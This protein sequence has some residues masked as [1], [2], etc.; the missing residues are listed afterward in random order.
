MEKFGIGQA[1]RRK[2]DVRL[3][4]GQG[5]YT[6][7]INLEGQAYSAILRSPLAH[8]DFKIIDVEAAKAMPGVIAVLTYEDTE[9]DGL[10]TIPCQVN[11]KCAT[12]KEMFTPPRYILAKDR[13]RFAGEPIAFVIAESRLQALDATEAIDVE[14]EELP[15]LASTHTAGEPDLDPIWPERPENF[16]AHWVSH[17]SG[18]VDKAF[19]KA[20]KT[21]TVE[22]VNNRVIGSPMEPR[23]AIGEY[24]A[25]TDTKILRSPT[26][27]VNKIRDAL[28]STFYKIDPERIRVIS[29]DTGGGFGVRSKMYLESILCLWAAEK[30]KRPVKWQAD[31]SETFLSDTHAR[32]QVSILE[33]AF[34]ED[35]KVLGMRAE[36][37]ANVGA[38]LSDN[39]PR[40][41]TVAGGRIA[42]TVYDVPAMRHSVRACFSNTHPTDSYRGA[43]RPELCYQME[44]LMDAGAEAFGIGRDEIRRR[45]YIKPEQL[46]YTNQMGMEIDSGRFQETMEMAIEVSD[47][48]NFE[49]RRTEA[50]KRGKLRG[51]GM[52]YYVEASG[53][54]PTEWARVALD[55]DGKAQ[56][57]VGTYN[58]GQ[59]HETAFG[60]ILSEK[61]G[62][63]FHNIDFHQGDTAVI[64]KGNGTGGS[65][66][67]Q[68][69]G[70]AI[71]RAADLVIEKAKKIAA[72]KMEAAA[73]DIEFN[74]GI[75]TVAGTDLSLPI[76]EVARAAYDPDEIPDD[77]EL[78]L[79]EDILYERDTECNFPN[80]CHIAEV[81]LDKET[82]EIEVV[83]YSAVDDCGIIINPLIVR[84]QV[85]GGVAMGLGQ[86]LTERT[87]YDPDTGQLITGSYMDYGMPRADDFPEMK[88]A[89]NM[90]RN[91]SNDLGVK[92]IGEGGACGAPPAIIGAISDALGITHIDMPVS[93]QDV[94]QILQSQKA[95]AE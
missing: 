65:R 1:V 73:A 35:A 41:P 21:V 48:D 93:S 61:L 81:E 40:I 27:G 14:Y 52:G 4:T 72:H 79:D 36:T 70:V 33:M 37:I 47:W 31:R 74:D 53:G 19:A 57:F 2:E 87:E 43:G 34:D 78:G 77:E 18:P 5:Q 69:G 44:R 12:G 59:G 28:A 32:D 83:A 51:I 91:P 29:T 56:L 3:V 49:P 30:L 62:I 95:A 9:A 23:V 22:L 13:V 20:H 42:G 26:Q 64:P 11:I 25:A 58:H 55:P 17:E 50:A 80:G 68:M 66:S 82:G 10:P 15:A 38:Y 84:G 39:G 7:D 16:A 6:D 67:S 92:G 90:V 45:N 75:F 94:W 71:A 89:F 76:S 85:H 46:P 24:D 86:A 8:A 60:Q 54:K 63:D 88:V